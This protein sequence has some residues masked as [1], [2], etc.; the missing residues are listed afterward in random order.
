MTSTVRL[1]VGLVMPTTTLYGPTQ[2][3]TTE[4]T[5]R[6]IAVK[7]AAELA[8]RLQGEAFLPWDVQGG[9]VQVIPTR[10]ITR[11]VIE[12]VTEVTP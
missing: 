3:V 5:P 2:T 12:D 4:G 7:A 6:E 10:L 9:D 1:R 11:L 8:D